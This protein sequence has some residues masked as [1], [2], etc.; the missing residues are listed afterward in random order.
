MGGVSRGL[1][2]TQRAIVALLDDGDAHGTIRELAG[3]IYGVAETSVG[4]RQNVRRAAHGLRH[5]QLVHAEYVANR[6]RG[7]VRAMPVREL[8]LALDD[9]RRAARAAR[10]WWLGH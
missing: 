7:G 8:L 9:E 3:S 1:G 4:Q 5:R 6:T 10:P 2:K